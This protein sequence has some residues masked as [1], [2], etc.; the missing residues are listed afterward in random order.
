MKIGSLHLKAFGP[1]TDRVMDFGGRGKSL[2][3]IYGPNEAGKSAML[4]AIEALRFQIDP[5]S[6]DNFRHDYTDM[7]V[8]GTFLNAEGAEV[9]VMRLKRLKDPLRVARPT[10]NGQLQVTDTPASS[11]LQE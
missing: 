8:G 6:P 4:R 7:C 10:G 11:G 3:M 9:S 1:F 2:V 5:R